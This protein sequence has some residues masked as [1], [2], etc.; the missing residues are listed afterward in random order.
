M[1]AVTANVDEEGEAPSEV[2]VSARS[3]GPASAGNADPEPKA[4]APA[5]NPAHGRSGELGPSANVQ[6][7]LVRIAWRKVAAV[8][9]SRRRSMSRA[10]RS[11]HR[12]VRR[13]A[14]RLPVIRARAAGG[15]V[16]ADVMARSVRE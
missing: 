14:R 5:P 11:G 16:A 9:R 12:L 3:E 8:G 15:D 1:A 4:V 6:A 7:S 10:A 2:V 13:V